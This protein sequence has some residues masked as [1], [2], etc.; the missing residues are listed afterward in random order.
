MHNDD[1]GCG[2]R[3]DDDDASDD[4]ENVV[5]SV[6]VGVV[7]LVAAAVVGCLF[8]SIA[9]HVQHVLA[10]L[11]GT[12]LVLVGILILE[13]FEKKK[14]FSFV[15]VAVVV[16]RF[17]EVSCCCHDRFSIMTLVPQLNVPIL[18]LRFGRINVESLRLRDTLQ[19]STGLMGNDGKDC[20]NRG[21]FVLI[22]WTTGAHR[23][24]R[25]DR[26]D[27]GDDFAV[28]EKE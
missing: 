23:L 17:V 22:S 1:G 11:I 9:V 10:L 3:D 21:S 13:S 5:V 20:L 28:K 27:E 26:N 16:V 2:R 24:L 8:V 19:R 18:P 14:S 4:I 7:V 25:G 15:V 12:S 6:V